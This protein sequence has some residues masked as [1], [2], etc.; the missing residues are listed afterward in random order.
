VEVPG[1]RFSAP[2]AYNAPLLPPVCHSAVCVASLLRR[3]GNECLRRMSHGM[4]AAVNQRGG[5]S[6]RDSNVSRYSDCESS[7]KSD[8]SCHVFTFGRLFY[9]LIDDRRKDGN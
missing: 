8:Y 4:R 2:F 7:R 5:V 3:I 1:G 6:R 9:R